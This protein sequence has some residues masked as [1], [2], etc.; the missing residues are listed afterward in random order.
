MHPAQWAFY[1][2]DLV[3]WLFLNFV[4]V[5]LVPFPDHLKQSGT[6]IVT[7]HYYYND[8]PMFIRSKLPLHKIFSDNHRATMQGLFFSTTQVMFL[9]WR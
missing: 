5:L 4:N 1:K 9:L 8:V 2:G 6:R 7:S 3:H